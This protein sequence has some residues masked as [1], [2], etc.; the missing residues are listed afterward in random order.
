MKG[1]DSKFDDVDNIIHLDT[2]WREAL[3]IHVNEFNKNHAFIMLNGS[4]RIMRN[5]PANIDIFG[6]DSFQFLQ[7]KDMNDLYLNTSIKIGEKEDKYGNISDIYSNHFKAWLTNEYRDSYPMGTVFVADKEPPEGCFNLWRGFNVK[8]QKTCDYPAIENHINGVICQHN[9]ELKNYFWKWLAWGFQNPDKQ[10]GA[11]VVLRGD[12]GAGKGIMADFLSE[13]WGRHSYYVSDAAQLTGK[14]NGHLIGICFL[15]ADE[16]FFSGDKTHEGTL[17]SRITQQIISVENKGE[18]AALNKNSL[19]ILMLTNNDWAVPVS[20]DERRFCVLDVSNV[21]CKN[22]KYFKALIKET[23][24]VKVQES[25]LFDM[26]NMDLG[27]WTP[28]NPP[29]SA[30]L[31]D[32][33]IHSLNSASAWLVDFLHKGGTGDVWCPVISKSELSKSYSDWCINKKI[34]PW[35]ILTDHKLGSHL[36]KFFDTKRSSSESRETVYCLGTLEE[37]IARVEEVEKIDIVS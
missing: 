4:A 32:Q 28:R 22:E 24:D 26:L 23:T 3:R 8:S 2:G 13:I 17:K 12:K 37:A 10:A 36:K 6:R 14:F 20:T 29:D 9:E 16:A 11:A 19:K 15:V 25:F 33:R 34:G 31:R 7:I 35:Q 21:F 18:Q 27:S 5:V 1:F 30:G